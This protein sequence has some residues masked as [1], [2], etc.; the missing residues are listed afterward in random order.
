MVDSRWAITSVVRSTTAA[1]RA[2]CTTAS[3]AA[4][5]ALVASSRIRIVGCFSRARAIAIRCRW[6]PL[7]WMP[8]SPTIVS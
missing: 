6:P 2:L 8:R 1:S 4:S 3:L 5:R 7:S